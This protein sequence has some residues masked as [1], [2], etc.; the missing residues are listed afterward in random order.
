MACCATDLLY[1]GN[2]MWRGGHVQLPWGELSPDP[3]FSGQPDGQ[4]YVQHSWRKRALLAEV[5]ALVTY[6]SEAGDY[7]HGGKTNSHIGNL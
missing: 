6:C 2:S 7:H 1:R 3:V 4:C 5:Q